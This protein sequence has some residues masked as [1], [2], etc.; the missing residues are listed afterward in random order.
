MKK[1]LLIEDNKVMRENTTEI[2]ELAGYKVVMASNGRIGASMAT[3]AYPDLIIC[4]IMMPE[5]DGYGVLHL[6]SNDPLTSSIPFIFLTAKAEKSEL[7]KGMELGADDYLTKPFDDKE[8]LKAI[9]VRLK[10]AELLNKKFSRNAEGLNEF[11]EYAGGISDLK[12]LS[13]KNPPYSKNKKDII[14]NEGDIPQYL[15]FLNK[16][17]V[18]T[19]KTHGD[20]KEFITNIYSDGDFFGHVSLFD[21]KAYAESC[22]VLERSEICKIPKDEFLALLYQNRDVAGQFIKML[23]NQIEGKEQQLLRLA[24][25]SVRKRMAEA[26]ITLESDNIVHITREDLAKLVGTST[27]SAIRCLSD[28]KE[29]LFIE[30]NGREIKILKKSGLESIQ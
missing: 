30:I 28:F 20:G 23:S 19:F 25:D 2:L 10:K 8:L 11:L 5:L 12:I 3:T 21:N 29:D 9:D 7:R 16:G 14:F 27:E 26:L 4:D 1:I 13:G 18:K 17:K 22:I 15:F 24:Y 6:L